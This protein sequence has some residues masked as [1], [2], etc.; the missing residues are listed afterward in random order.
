MKKL[1]FSLSILAALFT[2]C[3]STDSDTQT[4]PTVEGELSGDI[5]GTRTLEKGNYKLTSSI[6]VKSG[7]ILTI[8][9]GSVLTAQDNNGLI[10]LTVEKGGKIN[11]IGN[12]AE[13][14]ICTSVTKTP[15]AWG[16]IVLYGDA[17]IVPSISGTTATS[18]DGTNT[19]YGGSSNTTSGTLKYVRVEY[20]GRKIADG[21][22][23]LNA[24]SFYAVGSDTVL[25]HLVAYKGSDDGFEFYGGTVSMTNAIA[26][27]N[28]DDSFDWQDGW[29][30]QNNSNWYAYQTGTGNYG[31]EIEAKG[32]N[33]SFYPVVTGI[34]LKREAGTVTEGGSS[35]AE[36]DAIQFKKEG[37][38]FY[39]NILIEG[40]TDANA[41]A[42]R[43]QDAATN[44]N[45]VTGSK[46]KLTGVKIVGTTPLQ[47]VGATGFTVAFP[48][49]FYTTSTTSV[50]ASITNGAWSTVNGV[51]LI[52]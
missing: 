20:A 37:N 29:Q 6:R 30:G 19:T 16:G 39:T 28:T 44:T 12:A 18:E 7:G 27:G 13:P 24:F 31:M 36:Y 35:T 8:A 23:E 45:Q 43:I 40:Y 38:G 1:I 10:T 17:K 3:T 2:G 22:K 52:K 26:Y 21:T 15:G 32:V 51:S 34:T 47:G 25:D 48:T 5:T 49:G 11:L 14:I 33:N 50:G 9:A 4:K 41:V 46:I 42:V